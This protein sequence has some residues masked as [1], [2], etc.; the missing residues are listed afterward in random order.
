M[1][2]ILTAIVILLFVSNIH[3]TTRYWTSFGGNSNVAGNWNTV[4]GG[5]GATGVPVSG[6]VA[7]FDAGGGDCIIPANFS[8]G[9]G[10]ISMT[11]AYT[12]N[13]TFSGARTVT[14]GSFTCS[15]GTY[16]CTGAGTQNLGAIT[17]SGGTYLN[18]TATATAGSALTVSSG[19][20]NGGTKPV[21]ITGTVTISGGTLVAP[22]A[23]TFTIQNGDFLFTSGIFTHNS[24][25]VKIQMSA[26]FTAA[27]LDA[28]FTFYNLTIY[29]NT[30][31]NDLDVNFA[32]AEIVNGT[33]NLSTNGAYDISLL[34]GS[35]AANGNIVMSGYQGNNSNAGFAST[36]AITIG[37]SAVQIFTGNNSIGYG[38]LPNITIN[39][40]G[41]SLSLS[42]F[43][44]I[45]GVLTYTAGTVTTAGSTVT[46]YGTNNLNASG[47]PFNNLNIGESGIDVG[48]VTL[49]SAL[50]VNG[51]LTINTGSS[52]NTGSNYGL[53]L[54]GSLSN[55]GTLTVNSSTITCTGA[56][57]QSFDVGVTP[58][59]INTLVV[60]KSGNTVSVIDHFDISNLLTVTAGTFSTS[61]YVTLLSNASGTANVGPVGGTITGNFNVQRYVPV[62]G[63]RFRSLAA[64][65]TSGSNVSI[66]NGWQSQIFI[67][68]GTGGTGPV[69]TA[70]YNTNGFDW[71]S[72]NASSFFT[73]SEASGAWVSPANTTASYLTAGTGYRVLVRGDRTDATL[74]SGSTSTAQNAAVT[75]NV[76][77]AI[78]TGD[79]SV[80]VSNGGT[81][82]GWNL[83]GNPYPCTYDFN[84]QFTAGVGITNILNT[85]TMF[86][87]SA[88]SYKSYNASTH[89]GTL[90][91]GLIPSGGSFWVQTTGSSPAF[92][93][94]EAYKSTSAPAQLFKT[95][96]QELGI[97]MYLDSTEY[98]QYIFSYSNG[99]TKNYDS[100]DIKKMANP[101]TNLSSYGSDN[102]NLTYSSYPTIT[103]S[104]DTILLKATAANGTYYFYFSGVSQFAS[105]LDLFLIDNY[106]S[107]VTN[108]RSA[109]QYTFTINNAVAATFGA[110]RF[111]IIIS[112]NGGSLP[113]VLSK[114]TA[115]KSPNKLVNLSW[116]T[117]SEINNSHFDV[118][119]SSDQI[120][121]FK[122][123]EV[124]GHFNSI[125][126]NN[127]KLVDPTP[128][129]SAV[130]YYR[131]KQVDVNNKFTYSPVVPVDFNN[132]IITI[133]HSLGSVVNVYPVPA[134]ENINISLNNSYNGDVTINIYNLVGKLILTNTGTIS[135]N[136]SEISQNISN[137]NTGI[138]LIEVASKNGEFK[139]Q[140]K[141]VKE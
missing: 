5:G 109:S 65:V 40:S 134:T 49:A 101:S 103:S 32:G 48:S 122:I 77:G 112:N 74:L 140:S 28:G 66:R 21:A 39:K 102:I 71:T 7:V 117:S 8:V 124:K 81:G 90:T 85:V 91:S 94:K 52:F 100:Y 33:L 86:D 131:L 31:I 93:F 13:I 133:N 41:G 137:L 123:G 132:D 110:N 54:A 141:F 78:P 30:A 121:Y 4:S 18:S 107:T 135:T 76:T 60:N 88:N 15:G 27:N 84:A 63:R 17:I 75:L 104:A 79:F 113:I 119:R 115:E 10:S 73:Y 56:S 23:N 59:T 111:M 44:N 1:K 37:G 62:S 108:L 35:I 129:L 138:Y 24:G 6:D 42:G 34:G 58:L 97:K 43:V 9:A 96:A 92:T 47:I 105:N 83:I 19:T 72:S 70:N 82:A 89:S 46:I 116:V 64:P 136:N 68:G 38:K 114:F 51:N 50:N 118:E 45:Y 25:T 16:N 99:S 80:S 53:T 87:A 2:K 20:F 98:D 29:N 67:T 106:T 3:A 36:T 14:A 127:Y 61:G 139:E 130:N 69:G 11:A 126:T 120:N 125:V 128:S 12:G 26:V 22:N 55:L 95:A 57:A